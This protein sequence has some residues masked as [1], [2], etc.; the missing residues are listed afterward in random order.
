[1]ARWVLFVAKCTSLIWKLFKDCTNYSLRYLG[2]STCDMPRSAL[3]WN[4]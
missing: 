4:I 3:A 1:M 2:Q